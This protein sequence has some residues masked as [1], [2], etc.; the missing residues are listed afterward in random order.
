MT[1]LVDAAPRPITPGGES[2]EGVAY[3]QAALDIVERGD[4]NHPD[5]PIHPS[6]V[7]VCLR[8][9]DAAT[10]KIVRLGD[11][12]RAQ[13]L[14]QAFVASLMALD[15]H[16]WALDTW[17]MLY[18]GWDEVDCIIH[19]L[20]QDRHS[21]LEG[22]RQRLLTILGNLLEV[23][24]AP[25]TQDRPPLIARGLAKWCEG[26]GKVP[27]H[28]DDVSRLVTI[29]S[30]LEALGCWESDV[31]TALK[32][33]VSIVRTWTWRYPHPQAF[34]SATLAYNGLVEFYTERRQCQ[35]AISLLE[36]LADLGRSWVCPNETISEHLLPV[37][38]ELGLLY[39]QEGMPRKA[40]IVL[41]EAL[42]LPGYMDY[43][44]LCL[45]EKSK[46]HAALGERAGSVQAL[47]EA[48]ELARASDDGEAQVQ[49]VEWLCD[50]IMLCQVTDSP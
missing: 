46:V 9:S 34:R 12:Q 16:D 10:A 21:T 11:G 7:E 50:L 41:E 44:R 17:R 20:C 3:L 5:C 26:I 22:K 29:A 36:E 30:W 13:L 48:V 28:P 43:H 47:R 4:P 14:R 37:L 1:C 31:L 24:G 42:R 33:S 6:Y 23:Q 2:E 38:H 39:H 35:P 19:R 8:L 49:Q 15:M 27:G 40:L 32:G 25:I 45:R 18:Q